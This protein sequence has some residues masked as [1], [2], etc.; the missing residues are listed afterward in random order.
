MALF[1]HIISLGTYLFKGVIKIT[2]L[3][4][5][6]SS[7]TTATRV[8]KELAQ[9]KFPA[10]VIQT[11]KNLSKNGCSY[12]VK[13]SSDALVLAEKSAEKLGVKVKNVFRFDGKEYIN[14]R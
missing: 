6:F 4:I 9:N 3:L 12:S 2:D 11:P 13:T 5:T 7:A 14:I 8:K 10:Q 1:S